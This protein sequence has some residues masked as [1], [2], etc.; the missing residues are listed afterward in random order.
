MTQ[1]V[2]V[3]PSDDTTE[4]LDGDCGVVLSVLKPCPDEP[5]RIF[6]CACGAEV[7]PRH[8]PEDE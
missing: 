2:R 6:S 8:P 3:I 5:H 4:L 7:H 1:H